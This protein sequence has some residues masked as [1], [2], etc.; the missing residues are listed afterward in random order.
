[1]ALIMTF[2]CLLESDEGIHYS[3]SLAI[4]I[5]T[6]NGAISI[7]ITPTNATLL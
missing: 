7:D 6:H 2:V 3:L 5:L 4:S 1:M